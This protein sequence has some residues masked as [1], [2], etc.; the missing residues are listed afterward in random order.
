MAFC[1]ALI[2]A[3]PLAAALASASCATGQPAQ[4]P[5]P[6][7]N[8]L[9]LF[10]HSLAISDGR[11]VLLASDFTGRLLP[12]LGSIEDRF[13]RFVFFDLRT[14]VMRSPAFPSTAKAQRIAGNAG[15]ALVA[16]FG[17]PADTSRDWDA[18]DAKLVDL[19]RSTSGPTL[20][21]NG[22]YIMRDAASSLHMG[23]TAAH[24]ALRRH[25][26]GIDYVR[27]D[28]ATDSMHRVRLPEPVPLY[29]NVFSEE[30]SGV[31][32]SIAMDRREGDP[33][34]GAAYVKVFGLQRD[35]T[36][37]LTVYR[38]PT[39]RH[40]SSPLLFSVD[41]QMY[42][43]WAEGP[44]LFPWDVRISPLS[45]DR[46]REVLDSVRIPFDVP[47]F[48]LSRACGGL[49][50]AAIE[51]TDPLTRISLHHW[52]GTW[53]RLEDVRLEGFPVSLGLAGDSARVLVSL[54]H[55][56]KWP[57]EDPVESARTTMYSVSCPH[58]F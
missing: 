18:L 31:V 52:S 16:A 6:A 34:S 14:Q 32:A 51:T 41:Q 21:L 12:H 22:P 11:S 58:E 50:V 53:Q 54:T 38:V 28:P 56:S 1:R 49:I 42:V 25:G 15:G 48:H 7:L 20:E 5:V 37:S 19:T 26:S 4:I 3:Y 35:I 36:E 29:V 2:A 17:V 23:E 47:G 10:E 24:L 9:T 13:R 39:G 8:D 30:G 33:Q 40:A 43:A 46:P 44:G 45:L 27:W 57:K 55:A